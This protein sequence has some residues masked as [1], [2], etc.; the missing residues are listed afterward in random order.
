MIRRPPRST[1]FPYTTLFRSGT[2]AAVDLTLTA[3]DVAE[4]AVS[5]SR[6]DAQF[7]QLGEDPRYQTDGAA[8]VAGTLRLE[9]FSPSH[10]GIA[11]P[12][13]VRYASLAG[14]P[15]YLSGTDIRADALQGL[16]TPRSTATSYAL[17]IRRTARAASP[18][19]R[20]L[21]DPLALSG[22][23]ASGNTRSDLA[24][25]TASSFSLNL[26]YSLALAR[27][28]KG[29]RLL[30]TGVRFHSGLADERG[31][32]ASYAV[33]VMRDSDAAIVPAISRSKVWRNSGGVDLV[34]LPSVLLRVD[35]A[36]LR[37]LRD[38]GDS[39]TIGRLM[40]GERRSL[41][42]R[43]VGVETQRTLNTFVGGTPP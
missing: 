25:A 27:R 35:A 41:L 14:D 43:D 8:S 23:W 18:L 3:A 7:R 38:Y 36:S 5:A 21:V 2:A 13:T 9:R 6:R 42:G 11:A 31:S 32:L 39:T 4:V 17:S 22:A 28:A 10:W 20:L 33:P 12:L 15:F 1:L 30:P 24:L 19:L 16:R 40:G 34:P 29:L 37:D 26:D